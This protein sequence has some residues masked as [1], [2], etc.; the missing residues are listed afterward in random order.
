METGS[1]YPQ[2]VKRAEI[3]KPDGSQRQLGIPTVFDRFIQQAIAQ[4]LQSEWEPYFHNRSY[5]FRPGR[6]AHQAIRYSQSTIQS[7]FKW[8]VDCDLALFFDSVH[9]D[10]LMMKLKARIKEPELLRLIN[11]FLK[12]GVQINGN[13]EASVEGVPQGGPLSPILANILLDE[14]DWELEARGH[15]FVRYADDFIVFTK[16]QRAAKRIMV[17]L[18]HFF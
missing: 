12:A 14:L 17:S 4:V 6:S 18:E 1:Y 2:P 13:V 11:R 16:S 8:I 3:P 15:Q 9:H 7:G 10:V 5:G